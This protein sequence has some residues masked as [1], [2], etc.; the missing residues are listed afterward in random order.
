MALSK[1]H[2]R[3]IGR[4]FDKGY[5]VFESPEGVQSVLNVLGRL[6]HGTHS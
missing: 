6:K 5:E 2:Q 4:V 1:N 3:A